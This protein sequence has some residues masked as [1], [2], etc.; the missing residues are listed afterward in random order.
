MSQSLSDP[1]FP[2]FGAALAMALG[3]AVTATPALAGPPFL[4]DD[5]E[6]TEPGHWEIYNF[7]AGAHT[8]G[9]T[10]GE[11]GIDL[12]YGAAKDLQLTAVFPVAFEQSNGGTS[13]TGGVIE[14]AV[15]YKV[16]HQDGP[17][18][19]DVAVF[20]RLFVPTHGD[21]RTNLFLPV[22]AQK[23]YGHW[24]VFGGGG[25]DLNPGPGQ[26]NYW[27]GG[28]GVSRQVTKRLML[29]VEAYHRGAD[30]LGGKAYTALNFGGAWK[31]T[32]H[33]SVLASTGPGVENARSEGQYGF[34]L[35]LKADY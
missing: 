31:A 33:W 5:P 2:R 8:P 10:E 17:T 9:L 1:G 3:L 20:P 22:W 14:L 29:G 26:R 12:N 6:P 24:S 15:K 18:G 4:N 7:V 23:D 16:L 30:S 27:L 19:L 13:V 28:V 34:Y 32:E 25:Y 35:S 11:A 21:A